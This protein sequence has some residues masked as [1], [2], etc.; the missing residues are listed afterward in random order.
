MPACPGGMWAETRQA[1]LAVTAGRR[2]IAYCE[3]VAEIHSL[4]LDPQ[5]DCLAHMFGKISTADH[6]AGRGMLTVLVIHKQGDQMPDPDLLQ[7]ART[8]GRAT[9]GR[10]VFRNSSSHFG[11]VE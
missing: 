3:F 9:K 4:D 5:S 1:I 7:L 10:E 6:G 8:L 11:L 2:V